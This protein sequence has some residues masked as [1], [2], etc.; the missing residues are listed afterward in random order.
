MVA[1]LTTMACSTSSLDRAPDAIQVTYRPDSS[2]LTQKLHQ[3]FDSI[4][5]QN[6]VFTELGFNVLVPSNW[7]SCPTGKS[8]LLCVLDSASNEPFKSNIAVSVYPSDNLLDFKRRMFTERQDQLNWTLVEDGENPYFLT[9]NSYTSY[10]TVYVQNGHDHELG[11]WCYA[12]IHK[13]RVIDITLAGLL[14]D[15]DRL[16]YMFKF[17]TSRIESL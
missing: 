4:T 1:L 9:K 17:I 13:D 12:F 11:F 6:F 8:I 10:T 5:W 3:H 2:Q 15:V 16:D 7:G 14:S